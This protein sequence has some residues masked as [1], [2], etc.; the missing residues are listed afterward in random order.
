MPKLRQ[1]SA[2]VPPQAPVAAPV[3]PMASIAPPPVAASP[4]QPIPQAPVA[5]VPQAPVAQAPAPVAQPV[6]A[7][8]PAPVAAAPIPQ[9]VPVASAPVPFSVGVPGEASQA[10]TAGAK[11]AESRT[12]KI[13]AAVAGKFFTFKENRKGQEFSCICGS[14]GR[15]AIVCTA[16][17]IAT[18]QPVGEVL[19]GANCFARLLGQD[20]KPLVLPKVARVA[21]AGG[22]TTPGIN[23][24][25]KFTNALARFTAP[26]VFART[27]EGTFQCFCGGNGVNQVVIRDANGAEFSVGGRCAELIPGVQVPKKQRA[28]KAGAPVVAGLKSATVAPALVPPFAN[29]S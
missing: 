9:P 21:S 14:T 7:P 8:I 16:Y 6:P 23:K 20:G 3:A 19:V 27:Q 2:V 13:A 25:E 22:V 11:L 5:P 1:P 17:D 24:Q 28:S 4:V 12:N 26:F 10:T 18:A 15:N 29:V